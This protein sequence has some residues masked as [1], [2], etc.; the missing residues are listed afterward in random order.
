MS[1]LIGDRRKFLS[2]TTLAIGSAFV[3]SQVSLAQAS[4]KDAAYPGLIVREKEPLNLE[5]PFPTL[6]K[7][8]TP[9]NRFFVRSH[10]SIPTLDPKAW[11]L[12]IDGNVDHPLEFSLDDIRKM[13]AKT[14]TATIECAGNGR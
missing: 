14:L 7:V 1:H 2:T 5:F 3:V 8:M 13:T 10:F 9:T 11:R 4:E 12:K 6:D